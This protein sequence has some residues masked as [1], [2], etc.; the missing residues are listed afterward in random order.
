MSEPDWSND[1]ADLPPGMFRHG[2]PLEQTTI[3]QK[4]KGPLRHSPR[5]D[6]YPKVCFSDIGGLAIYEGDIALGPAVE[7]RNKGRSIG[8]TGDLWPGGQVPYELNG[9]NTT[10]VSAA[11][12]HWEAQTPIRFVRRAAEPDFVSFE[13]LEGCWSYVGKV[14]GRQQLSVGRGCPLGS[15]IHEIGHLLGLWH[16]QSRADR[17][18]HIEV[19][20][21]NIAEEHLHNFDQHILD[22]TDL[23]SYD[24]GSIMHYPPLAFSKNGEPTIVAKGGQSIGQRNGLSAGDVQGVR[25][26]YPD[27]DWTAVAAQA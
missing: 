1:A 6:R 14:G 25:L 10:L 8:T 24:F 4:K 21:E 20:S 5:E 13:Q 23:G 18:D 17:D 16:E 15:V 26:L 3:H 9:A 27:L 19:R 12:A 7:V 22:G 2:G 11:I